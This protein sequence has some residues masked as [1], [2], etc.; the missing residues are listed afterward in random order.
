MPINDSFP[1]GCPRRRAKYFARPLQHHGQAF[2]NTLLLIFTSFEE[3]HVS[4]LG[5]RNNRR[6]VVIKRIPQLRDSHH[7]LA[8]IFGHL[9]LVVRLSLVSSRRNT[10][11]LCVCMCEQKRSSLNVCG[12]VHASANVYACVRALTM[13][14]FPHASGACVLRRFF[15][16]RFAAPGSGV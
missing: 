7:L 5:I 3:R 8:L 10:L 12:D 6:G 9:A 14:A 13:I 11:V 1:D 16:P 15:L 2:R 4:P